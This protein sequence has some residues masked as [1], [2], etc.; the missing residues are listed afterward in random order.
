MQQGP[1]YRIFGWVCVALAAL[2]FVWFATFAWS[3]PTSV[4]AVVQD[5]VSVL[6]LAAIGSSFLLRPAH[7]TWAT[8]AMAVGVAC[9]AVG[10]LLSFSQEIG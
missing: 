4:G 3:R 1:G 7:P 8:R 6:G 2:A 5:L 10:L 9:I